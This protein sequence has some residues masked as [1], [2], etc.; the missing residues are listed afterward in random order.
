MPPREVRFA[1]GV[2][3][4]RD[5]EFLK[6]EAVYLNCRYID[7]QDKDNGDIDNDWPILSGNSKAFLPLECLSCFQV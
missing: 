5:C 1:G 6:T 7:N 4:T 2:N 3:P